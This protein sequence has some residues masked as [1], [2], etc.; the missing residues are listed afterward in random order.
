MTLA[1][2]HAMYG[3][4]GAI[5]RHADAVF[6]RLSPEQ[7]SAARSAL[8]KLVH[9]STLDSYTRTRRPLSELRSGRYPRARVKRQPAGGDVLR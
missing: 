4:N 3:L 5:D 2:Y 7:Q 8:T 6:A 1:A 9:V